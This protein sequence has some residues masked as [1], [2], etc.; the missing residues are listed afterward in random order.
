MLRV[1]MNINL[2]SNGQKVLIRD[3]VIQRFP[4]NPEFA[5]NLFQWFQKVSTS[6]GLVTF[7]DFIA[8][9]KLSFGG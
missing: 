4:E 6:G 2:R 1:D 3:A 8:A 7:K 5:S 9:C